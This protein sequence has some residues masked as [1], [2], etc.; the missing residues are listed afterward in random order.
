M[1][2]NLVW[3]NRNMSEDNN[4]DPSNSVIVGVKGEKVDNKEQSTSI[5]NS[6]DDSAKEVK[7]PTKV[8][9]M[10]KIWELG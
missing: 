3:N 1:K 7:M 4:K 5:L 6:T 8:K 2:D 9:I 10:R